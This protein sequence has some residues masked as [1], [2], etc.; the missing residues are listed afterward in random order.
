MKK[1]IIFSI[2]FQ[3]QS[4]KFQ[5]LGT[6]NEIRANFW[7]E[8]NIVTIYFIYGLFFFKEQKNMFLKA[9]FNFWGPNF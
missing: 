1:I 4:I 8:N 9:Q 2:K 3:G 7:D 5:Y 6:K